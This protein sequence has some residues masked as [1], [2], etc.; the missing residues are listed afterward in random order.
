MYTVPL[1]RVSCPIRRVSL[2]QRYLYRGVQLHVYYYIYNYV[3]YFAGQVAFK[4]ISKGG[5]L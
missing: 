2:F 1:D 4:N 3:G 5:I